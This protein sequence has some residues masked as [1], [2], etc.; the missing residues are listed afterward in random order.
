MKKSHLLNQIA[1]EVKKVKPDATEEKCQQFAEVIFNILK[2]LDL[3]IRNIWE[4][5]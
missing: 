2:N 3:K 4:N 5:E 1:I